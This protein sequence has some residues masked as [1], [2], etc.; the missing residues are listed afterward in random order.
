MENSLVKA[1]AEIVS[2][3]ALNIFQSFIDIFQSFSNIF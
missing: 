1:N 2:L 3:T